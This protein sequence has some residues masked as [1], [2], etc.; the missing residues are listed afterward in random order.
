LTR[1]IGLGN[2][3]WLL[4]EPRFW[5]AFIRSLVFLVFTVALSI[6]LGVIVAALLDHYFKRRGW[7]KALYLVP[8]VVTP[9]V[10]GIQWRF[11]L[12]VQFGVLNWILELL[13]LP[14]GGV[15]LTTPIGAMCWVMVVDIWYYTPVVI[16]LFGAGSESI[17]TCDRPPCW[18]TSFWA[19]FS[20]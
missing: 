7:L 13:G 4:Q 16:L 3:R 19:A 9:V 17:D 12:N 15:W 10:V 5:D 20:W 8:M 6:V 11:L 2:Y 18:R 14:I 1:F